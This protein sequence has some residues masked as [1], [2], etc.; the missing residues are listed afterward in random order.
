MKILKGLVLLMLFTVSSVK[1]DDKFTWMSASPSGLKSVFGCL[2]VPQFSGFKGGKASL[3]MVNSGKWQAST[4]NV[5]KGKLIKFN[6]STIGITPKPRR[7]LVLYRIDPRF[8]SPQ[9]FIK[10]Y[11]YTT[12]KFE[13]PGFVGFNTAPNGNIPADKDLAAL[14]FTKMPDYIKYFNFA[15]GNLKIPVNIGDVVNISLVNKSN[16][17]T[18]NTKD[19]ILIKELDTNQLAA[20]A[21]YTESNL[22]NYDNRIIYSSAAPICDLIDPERKSFCTGSAKATKYKTTDNMALVGKPMAIGAVQ[23]LMGSLKSCPSNSDINTSPTCYYDQGRGMEIKIGGTTIK[24][25]DANFVNSSNTQNSFIYYK[26]TSGGNLD[27]VTDWT[28][29][30]MFSSSIL[31]SN[32]VSKFPDFT[33]FTTNINTT[34]WSASFLYFGRYAMIVEIGN[35]DS[36]V[37]IVDQSNIKVEYI[38]APSG[39]LPDA[40][41]SGTQ[42]DQDFSVDAYQDGY[43]W[44]RV[45]D[46]TNNI[47][48]AISVDYANYTGTTWFSDI[49]YNK[50]IKPITDQF[51]ELTETFYRKLIGNSAVQNI[52]KA[53]LTLYVVIF[54]LMF[55]MGALKLT[56]QEVVTRIFKITIVA[57]LLQPESWDFFNKYLFSAFLDGIDYFF[58]NVVGASSSQANAFGF[59]DPIFD[60]YT[61]GR[62]W[63]LLFIQLLQIHTG[64]TFIAIMTIYGLILYFRAIL[65]VIIAYIIAFIGLSV[66]IS[67][68]P[69][70]II[71]M[72]FEKTKSLYD[73][74]LST[75]F[76]YV[77]QPTILLIFFLLIDQI[78]SEQLL[79]V[80]VRACWGIL[81]PIKPSFG[82]GHLGIP[83]NFS[84]TLPFLPG[85]PFFIP[86]V[87]AITSANLLT[88]NTNTFLVLFTTALLFFSYC[89]MSYGLVNYVS[90]VVAQLTNVTP[91]RQEGNYQA[92]SNPTQSIISDITSVAKPIGNAALAPA[93]IF[94]DKVIDQN[95]AAKPSSNEKDKEYTGKLFS[96]RNDVKDDKKD[97]K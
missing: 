10:T 83:L 46:T 77:M 61:N 47:Q 51:R 65:E 35:G 21:L 79:K 56:A 9:I 80:V 53:S 36:P 40:S 90:I 26:A 72:L 71:L 43:L 2:E 19:N 93:R 11:N 20:S 67:L 59:I 24:A 7:Y 22:G 78:L 27:F 68:A 18:N 15:N 14:A 89:L 84:F 69:F 31:M 41:T 34:D 38:I 12:N 5:E 25:R 64:L 66:M 82:L 4:N 55:V 86:D 3:N 49:V 60:K 28:P 63:G 62:I 39:T 37:S 91:A 29:S 58:R 76:S 95:Y 94:K 92:P 97:E 50:A 13:V 88:N 74:W 44:L 6:W 16:F 32:W 96:S 30:G 81:I 45:I 48:G 87:P 54:G 70:F 1:A 52:A 85:I 8:N 17:F 33:N 42:V 23:N 73:N 57:F 75:L